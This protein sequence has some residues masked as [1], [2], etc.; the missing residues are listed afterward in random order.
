MCI[1]SCYLYEAEGNNATFPTLYKR[2][3]YLN[4]VYSKINSNGLYVGK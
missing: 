1:N 3:S 4:S 2:L